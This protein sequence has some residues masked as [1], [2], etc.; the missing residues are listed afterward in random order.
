MGY[1]DGEASRMG[2]MDLVT[3]YMSDSPSWLFSRK[4]TTSEIFKVKPFAIHKER[5]HCSDLNGNCCWSSY[6][7][8]DGKMKFCRGKL[9]ASNGYCGGFMHGDSKYAFK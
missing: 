3:F 8:L 9:L 7:A 5:G 4:E 2:L 1:G 6:V